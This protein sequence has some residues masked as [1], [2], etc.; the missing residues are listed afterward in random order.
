MDLASGLYVPI[1]GSGFNVK[2]AP[3]RMFR[4][5]RN[6]VYTVG[7]QVSPGILVEGFV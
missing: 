2:P 5:D 6:A 4:M 7:N 3:A 1:P